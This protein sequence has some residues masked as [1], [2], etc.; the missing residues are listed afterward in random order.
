MSITQIALWALC[1]TGIVFCLLGVWFCVLF[2][3]EMWQDS[4]LHKEM[5]R[6]KRDREKSR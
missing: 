5:E 2:G 4:E 1:I 6:R 3:Y